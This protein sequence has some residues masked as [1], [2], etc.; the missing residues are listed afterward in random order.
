MSEGIKKAENAFF[1]WLAT[2]RT[3]SIFKVAAAAVLVWAGD[4]IAH[5]DL[6]AWV[7]IAAVAVIPMIINELNPKDSRYGITKG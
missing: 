7:M 3:G 2:T 1:E 5:W 4:S 6:P